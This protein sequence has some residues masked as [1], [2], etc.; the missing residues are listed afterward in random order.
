MTQEIEVRQS[1]EALSVVKENG[2][3][4]HYFYTQNLKYIQTKFRQ[5]VFKIGIAIIV[6]K[7]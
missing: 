3:E 7:K 6:L 2:T 1:E 4:V 5:E